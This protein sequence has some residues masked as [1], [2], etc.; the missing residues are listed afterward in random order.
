MTDKIDINKEGHSKMMILLS[1]G[2]HET[3]YT[4]MFTYRIIGEKEAPYW[5]D[6]KLLRQV[7]DGTKRVC[8]IHVKDVKVNG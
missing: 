1:L 6:V 4:K 3:L 5:I 2:L 7:L 8:G